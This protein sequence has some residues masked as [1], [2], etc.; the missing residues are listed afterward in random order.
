MRLVHHSISDRFP[1]FDSWTANCLFP[2]DCCWNHHRNHWLGLLY[3][4]LAT[5]IDA[6]G[7]DSRFYLAE[8]E[9]SRHP[10]FAR[11]FGLWFR[12]GSLRDFC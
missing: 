8:K 5:R 9:N 11:K 10:M 12:A 4:R 7:G 2:Y 3:G 6:L 1:N